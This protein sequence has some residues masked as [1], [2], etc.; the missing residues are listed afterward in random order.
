MLAQPSKNRWTVLSLLCV[1]IATTCYSIDMPSTMQEE[2]MNTLYIDSEESYS[3]FFGAMAFT[4]VFSFIPGIVADLYSVNSLT[5]PVPLI[6]LLGLVMQTAAVYSPNYKL[7]LA[8]RLVFGFGSMSL[9]IAKSMIN[10]DWFLGKELS[11]S[12]NLLQSVSRILMFIGAALSSV[13]A[14]F[15]SITNAFLGGII[16]GLISLV[17]A[18]L[19][20]YYQNCFEIERRI[21]EREILNL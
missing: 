17:A 13:I 10:R 21:M 3:Y 11:F 2:L 19:L 5:V 1:Y 18:I 4:A 7:F 15:F 20:H 9:N 6:I 16:V 14:N 8:G 12:I